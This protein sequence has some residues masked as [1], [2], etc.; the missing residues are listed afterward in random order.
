MEYYDYNN[1][2]WIES[3]N[4]KVLVI[5][6]SGGIGNKLI[7]LLGIEYDVLGINSKVM[8]LSDI[9]EV[10]CFIEK[11]Q[12]E[13]IINMGGINI[14][15]TVVNLSYDNINQLID[16]NYKGNINLIKAAVPMMIKKKFGRIILASSVLTRKTVFG[17]GIYSS[18]KSAIE[19]L[20][21]VAAVETA[22][23]NITIN[24]LRMGYMDG[25]LTYRIPEDYLSEIRSSIPKKV[26]GS[27]DNIANAV[28][29]LI[30]SDYVTGT[31]IEIDGG[32]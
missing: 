3:E 12:P 19:T 17:T 32:L 28:K 29:F 10:T 5:G 18:L 31:S 9:H 8:D 4:M 22:R 23:Y 24:C 14:D 25:G 1:E 30:N 6:S 26:F 20:T 16:V 13:V 15:G 21:R 2:E 27:I 7:S 11:Q